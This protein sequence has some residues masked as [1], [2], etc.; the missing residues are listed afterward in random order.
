MTYRER[1]TPSVSAMRCHLPLQGRI[2]AI[3][4]NP[5]P[6]V[7]LANARTQGTIRGS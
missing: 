3:S 6:S 5:I 7:I 4:A 1:V 2:E